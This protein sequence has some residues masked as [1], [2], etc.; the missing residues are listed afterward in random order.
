[1]MMRAEDYRREMPAPPCSPMA[2]KR[3]SNLI[4]RA[5][6]LPLLGKSSASVSR[7]IEK[8]VPPS[9][10]TPEQWI[11][12]AGYEVLE[13]LGDD[14]H[15]SLFKARD[16]R[17][18]LVQIRLL[19][20][21]VMFDSAAELAA[22]EKLLKGLKHAAI[23]PVLDLVIVAPPGAAS[24]SVIAIVSEYVAAPT[25]TERFARTDTDR[26]DPRAAAQFVLALGEALEYAAGRSLVHGNLTPD[27]ILIGDNDRP[28]IGGFGLLRVRRCGCTS[29]LK[30]CAR[31]ARARR[32]RAMCI[33]W[34]S[35]STGY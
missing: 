17:K 19:K 2:S 29:L 14:G 35:C 18:R 21:P 5:F 31:Q 4:A 8:Q 32:L 13:K 10:S 22:V 15:G 30:F 34:A 20:K 25:L 26:L 16:R 3:R 33:V 28:R 12:E 27:H 7:K 1:M 23:V 11:E 24:V 9:P 6:H